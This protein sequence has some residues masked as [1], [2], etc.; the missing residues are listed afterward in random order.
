MG[1]GPTLNS[2]NGYEP[3]GMQWRFDESYGECGSVASD[4]GPPDFIFGL[5]LVA[6]MVLFLG[7]DYVAANQNRASSRES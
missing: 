4:I 1:S 6:L 2:V 5:A 7:E 3:G